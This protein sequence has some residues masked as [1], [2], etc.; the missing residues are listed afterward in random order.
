VDE[1]G[2]SEPPI[3]Q[4]RQHRRLHRGHDLAGLGA[5]HRE[6]ENAVV[7]PTRT[8]MKPCVSSVASVRSTALIGSLVNQFKKGSLIGAVTDPKPAMK[9][10]E[11]ATPKNLEP[12]TTHP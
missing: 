11:T 7:A 4:V 5:N 10:S 2:V 12:A 6:A 1:N 3:W 9:L 8:F